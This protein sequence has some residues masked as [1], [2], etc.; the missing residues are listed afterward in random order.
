MVITPI[1]ASIHYDDLT[2]L[3][4]VKASREEASS[5]NDIKPWVE[6]LEDAINLVQA[7][8]LLLD[9]WATA[10]S[11]VDATV[12]DLTTLAAFATARATSFTEEVVT[13]PPGDPAFPGS[14]FTGPPYDGT[15]ANW[16]VDL[17]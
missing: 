12:G 14:T 2:K 16:G 6:L 17:S 13:I 11:T 4:H 15:L 8:Q 9:W 7:I 1:K 5:P 3:W 10:G